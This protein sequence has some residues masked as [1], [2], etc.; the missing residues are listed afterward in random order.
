MRQQVGWLLS[1]FMMYMEAKA[2]HA[3]AAVTDIFANKTLPVQ[4]A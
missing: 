3:T 4:T 1:A 2:R